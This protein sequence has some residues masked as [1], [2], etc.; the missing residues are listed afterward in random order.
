MFRYQEW[1]TRALR[2]GYT[3]VSVP[4]DDSLCND[5]WAKVCYCS[6]ALAYTWFSKW[7]SPRLM[8]TLSLRLLQV[9]LMEEMVREQAAAIKAAKHP[10][11]WLQVRCLRSLLA[12]PGSAGPQG[13]AV[14]PS[15][16]HADA[17]ASA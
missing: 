11:P 9:Q 4:D 12:L 15:L 5:T 16:P 7:C 17:K 2:N 1:Y 14:L 3:H 6:S 10:P 8:F 13:C